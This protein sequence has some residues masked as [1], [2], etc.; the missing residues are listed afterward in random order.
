[1]KKAE[2][3]QIRG[4]LVGVETVV[5]SALALLSLIETDVR[6][7]LTCGKVPTHSTR[8]CFL[9]WGGGEIAVLIM[10]L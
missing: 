9:M 8:L 3:R 7:D 4:A 10:S 6:F 1:M 2:R 5:S